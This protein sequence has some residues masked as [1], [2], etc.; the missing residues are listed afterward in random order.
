M[1]I[2]NQ[3]NTFALKEYS[4]RDLLKV[5]DSVR[6]KKALVIDQSVSGPLSLIA[7]FNLLK[8]SN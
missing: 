8:V 7:E 5:L 2:E 4:K 1:V 6:G 3:F